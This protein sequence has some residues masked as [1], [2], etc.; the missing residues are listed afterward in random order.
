M[1]LASAS[2]GLMMKFTF[3]PSGRLAHLFLY[4][5]P[6]ILYL[7]LFIMANWSF[8]NY[9]FLLPETSRSPAY[10]PCCRAF[11]TFRMASHDYRTIF[12]FVAFIILVG[13]FGL[14]VE[15]AGYR[16]WAG[17]FISW[18]ILVLCATSAFVIKIHKV[19]QIK[20]SSIIVLMLI[21]SLIIVMAVCYFV[22][23]LH[24]TFTLVT[25]SLLIMIVGYPA[26]LIFSVSLGLPRSDFV[27]KVIF[28][29][30]ILLLICLLLITFA[31]SPWQYGAIATTSVVFGG[32]SISV[33]PIVYSTNKK[34]FDFIWKSLLGL[35]TLGSS[36]LL[37]IDQYGFIGFSIICLLAYFSSIST[38]VSYY[39]ASYSKS[40]LPTFIFSPY[41]LPIFQYIPKNFLAPL[42]CANSLIG[43]FF[44]AVQYYYA[45]EF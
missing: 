36:L 19:S 20:S 23:Y 29:A 3:W 12:Y 8:N 32:A 15:S 4:L 16:Y 43:H 18:S 35:L 6:S 5:F 11:W 44:I 38:L 33:F 14:F 1:I 31:Y 21:F 39:S 45:F 41:I 2:I 25:P 22:I 37:L 17:Y 27:A 7:W 28:T 30:L 40:N 26:L 42:A 13:S 10:L 34:L 9:N 24:S